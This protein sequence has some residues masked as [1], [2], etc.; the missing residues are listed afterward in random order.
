VLSI[1]AMGPAG[2]FNVDWN[3]PIAKALL[4]CANT[5]SRR[6]GYTGQRPS[7]EKI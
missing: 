5:I 6:L 3:S 2:T 4:D 7:R 1:T